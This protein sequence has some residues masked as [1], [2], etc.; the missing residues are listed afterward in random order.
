[1][2]YLFYIFP[3]IG[4]IILFLLWLN[5]KKL[6]NCEKEAARNEIVNIKKN[7]EEE[8][9]KKVS[10]VLQE[11]EEKI[12]DICTHAEQQLKA[13]REAILCEKDSLKA[14]EEKDLLVEC[15]YALGTYAQ[16]LDRL[17][18]RMSNV[19]ITVNEVV[20]KVSAQKKAYRHAGRITN[21]ELVQIARDEAKKYDRITDI[22]VDD[23][24]V[25]GIVLSQHKLS[26]WTFEID[27]NDNGELTGDYTISSENYDST[28]PQRLA[29]E[30]S[31]EIIYR[32]NTK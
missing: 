4:C 11:T 31:K 3:W 17:E 8:T 21:D 18:N 1:M 15:M 16:R 7:A 24:L 26:T 13:E 22:A 10:A 6:R 5:E 30:I 27:F 32:L 9:Q 25:K 23:A 29:Q 19:N 20:R 14:L 28:I 12:S 2:E